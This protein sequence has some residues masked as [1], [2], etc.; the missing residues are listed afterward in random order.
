[1]VLGLCVAEVLPPLDAGVDVAKDLGTDVD[2]GTVVDLGLGVVVAAGAA[3]A[4]VVAG[5]G[6]VGGS[7]SLACFLALLGWA[8]EDPDS[9]L[10]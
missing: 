7:G 9:G 10:G 3:G 6:A 4:A 2:L 8:V 5:A 1:M